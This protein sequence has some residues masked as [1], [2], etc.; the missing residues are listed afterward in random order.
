MTHFVRTRGFDCPLNPLLPP[1]CHLT[2]SP[3]V[4]VPSDSIPLHLN[5]VTM[6]KLP[7]L[8]LPDFPGEKI[9]DKVQYGVD[10]LVSGRDL[11]EHL[12]DDHRTR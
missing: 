11:L 2:S 1:T 4:L 5:R 8:V 6:S 12:S 3:M 9:R 7:P 10:R